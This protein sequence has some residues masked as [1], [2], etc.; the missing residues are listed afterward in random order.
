MPKL[1]ELGFELLRHPQYSPDLAT[2]GYWL[3]VDLKK[4]LQGKRFVSNDKVI[5][6]TNAYF[7]ATDKSFYTAGIEKLEKRWNVSHLKEIM[8]MN[9]EEFCQKNFVLL[10]NPG[11]Y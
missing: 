10:V 11:T 7:G 4:M 5:A 3:F 9:K 1:D 6:E 2:S 8:L